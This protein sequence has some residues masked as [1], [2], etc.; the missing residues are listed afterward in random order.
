MCA[1]WAGCT[2]GSSKP[3]AGA[4]DADGAIYEPPTHVGFDE[5]DEHGAVR[6]GYLAD[7]NQG[8]DIAEGWI[9]YA[10]RKGGLYLVDIESETETRVYPNEPVN[11]DAAH[12]PGFRAEPVI[13]RGVIYTRGY[14]DSTTERPAVL[15]YDIRA[16]VWESIG[17]PP[18]ANPRYLD[19]DGRWLAW[20]DMRH[21]DEDG[22]S[23]DEVYLYD[24]DSRVEHRLTHQPVMQG[25]P[26]IS[27]D[28]IVWDDYIKGNTIEEIVLYTISTGESIYLTDDL[29]PQ[30]SPDIDG[31][32][33]VWTD[34]RNGEYFPGDGY[35]NTDVYLYRISTGEYVQ[36]TTDE[37]D[38]E[39][40]RI[41][42]K[43]IAWKDLRNGIRGP[44]GV[45]DTT[46]IFV[47]NLETSEEKQVT[48]GQG[49]MECCP[50]IY[51]DRLVYYSIRTGGWGSLWMVDLKRFWPD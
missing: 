15:A 40:P 31:D 42:G 30:F 8:H 12:Y 2:W 10:S 6:V 28:H 34:L 38:Q 48:F 47:Y 36:I 35:V 20:S 13:N 33:V 51:G 9:A 16:G 26:C 18:E 1:S 23:N 39:F 21:W 4:S 29:I 41:K 19:A 7:P 5:M 11:E 37:H 46:N 45:P 32:N 17:T 43:Y 25:D 22:G 50:R 3:D 49:Y 24:L 44:D 14:N 27:G